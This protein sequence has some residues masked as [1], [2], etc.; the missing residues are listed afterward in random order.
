MAVTALQTL[1]KTHAAYVAFS[2]VFAVAA[3]T[4]RLLQC[5]QLLLVG[6]SGSWKHRANFLISHVQG[7]PAQFYSPLI[8]ALHGIALY[9][10]AERKSMQ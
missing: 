3:S 4:R 1:V 6:Q 9:G 7:S 5:L 8:T 10:T 2:P